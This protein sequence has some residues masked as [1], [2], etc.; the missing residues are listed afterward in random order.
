MNDDNFK[1]NLDPK[2]EVT[3]GGPFLMQLL[4]SHSVAMPDKEL[5][6]AAIWRHVGNVDCFCHDKKT[7]GFAAM[8]H[9][10]EFKDGKVPVQLMVTGCSKFSGRNIDQFHRSQM[11]DCPKEERERIL[12]ECRY[13]IIGVD[14][15][16]SALSAIERANLDMDF[17]E[18]LVELYPD[19]EAIY[20]QNC[21]KLIPI[22]DIRS[23]QVTG[24]D[25]FIHFGVNARFF[26]I[27]DTDDMLIDTLGM[28]TLYLPDLQ[29]HFHDLDPNWIVNHAYNVASYILANNNPIDDG[30]TVDGVIDGNITRDVMWKCQYEHAMIQPPREVL[31]INTGEYASGA[32]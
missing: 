1:Q 25:R 5:M 19:C 12:R 29:Y 26:N 31:D 21:G 14:M 13:Q 8:E 3:P 28:S 2:E 32:R 4:F 27:Q 15:L 9:I 17:M 20:F 22:T 7:A 30:E 16:T 23:C 18:A 24:P 11:W 10:A 6:T